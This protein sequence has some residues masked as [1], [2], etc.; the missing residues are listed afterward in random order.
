MST[1]VS[2]T[3]TPT[4]LISLFLL[5]LC[6]MWYSR[7]GVITRSAVVSCCLLLK[8]YP[9]LGLLEITQAKLSRQ[10]HNNWMPVVFFQSPAIL[11]RRYRL[12]SPS[13]PGLSVTYWTSQQAHNSHRKES[14]S[15][16]L[17]VSSQVTYWLMYILFNLRQFDPMWVSL[18]SLC[19]RPSN[20]NLSNLCGLCK[21]VAPEI[22]RW[23]LCGISAPPAKDW[24]L[25]RSRSSSFVGLCQRRMRTLI[26]YYPNMVSTG[27]YLWS[28]PPLHNKGI[29]YVTVTEFTLEHNPRSQAIISFLLDPLFNPISPLS[30]YSMLICTTNR[31]VQ[32]YVIKLEIVRRNTFFWM[33]QHFRWL[34]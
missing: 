3:S 16:R 12:T 21:S 8:C 24:R 25:R 2:V 20:Y 14:R 18:I 29:W 30:R 4:L 33:E 7:K 22:V 28:R 26:F 27:A 6:I 34:S 11:A 31:Q 13:H 9:V 1:S 23:S 32:Q 15:G 17:S 5:V 10:W 19:H